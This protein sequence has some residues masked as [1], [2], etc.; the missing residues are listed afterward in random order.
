M[1]NPRLVCL[2]LDFQSLQQK[3]H[4]T[5]K[6]WAG[7][8]SLKLAGCSFTKQKCLKTTSE[9]NK[10]V[11]SG[12]VV[13]G[14]YLTC[15][16]SESFLT[17]EA[18][19][20]TIYKT[21]KYCHHCPEEIKQTVL[22]ALTLL[23]YS[24]GVCKGYTNDLGVVSKEWENLFKSTGIDL[25]LTLKFGFWLIPSFIPNRGRKGFG[26]TGR[27]RETDHQEHR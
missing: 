7:C 27:S 21:Y 12:T 19:F 3:K 18:G 20:T 13:A 23:M 5:W 4:K 8:W 16:V 17:D 1:I 15:I 24:V 6:K 25:L 10:R 2:T 14:L 26:Q 9:A 22:P 11:F